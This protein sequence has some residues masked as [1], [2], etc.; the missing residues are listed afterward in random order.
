MELKGSSSLSAC[1]N[2]P[3]ILWNLQ[4]TVHILL[5]CF[6]CFRLVGRSGV[7][8][9]VSTKFACD[10]LAILWKRLFP[11]LKWKC[12]CAL[13]YGTP[14][15]P[16]RALDLIP[17]QHLWDEWEHWL[18]AGPYHTA[19][20]PSPCTP[21]AE[22]EQSPA[23]RLQ[24]QIGSLPKGERRHLEQQHSAHNLKYEQSCIGCNA[25]WDSCYVWVSSASSLN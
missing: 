2:Q 5:G 12:P 11:V 24:N 19:S 15:G 9:Y 22:W 1:P 8:G 3:I 17:I 7:L 21:V 14:T 10:F 20:V 16:H 13:S 25:Y 23:A 18:W 4:C 6:S